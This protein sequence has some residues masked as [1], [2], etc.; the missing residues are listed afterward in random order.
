MKSAEKSHRAGIELLQIAEQYKQYRTDLKDKEAL[1]LAMLGN[2]DLAED[3]LGYP[4]RHD[5]VND[6]IK[7]L[8]SAR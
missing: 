6:V 5:A 7:Y 4:V 2:P 1:K 3:Y 8:T